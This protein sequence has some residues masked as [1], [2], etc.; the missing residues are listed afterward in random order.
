MR[1]GRPDQQSIYLD[2]ENRIGLDKLA[3]K[4]AHQSRNALI[5]AAVLFYLQYAMRPL[6]GNLM[7][8]TLESGPKLPTTE[9]TADIETIRRVVE[10]VLDEREKTKKRMAHP[11]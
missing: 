9:P 4:Y 5:N 2:D 10:Q 6:D 8:Y 3:K 1:M 11:S 7:T